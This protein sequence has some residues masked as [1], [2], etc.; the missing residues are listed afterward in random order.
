MGRDADG[1]GEGF[2]F[3]GDA[4]STDDATSDGDDWQEAESGFQFET[5]EEPEP[6]ESDDAHAVHDDHEHHPV[7]ED[8]PRGVGEA[9][10]WP[11]LTAI[12]AAAVY[13]SAALFLLGRGRNSIVAPEIGPIAFV[14]AVGI[15]LIGVYGWLYHG[16]IAHFWTRGTDRRS[17]RSL[18]WG[19]LGFIASEIATFGALFAY[20]F[21]IRAGPWPPADSLLPEIDLLNVLVVSNTAVLVLSSVT[22]HFAHHSLASG[23]RERFHRLLGITIGLGGLFLAGQIVE[24]NEFIVFEGVDWTSGVFFS[25]FFGLT[26]LHGLHV[27][28]GT[29]LLVIT[30]VRGKQGQFDEERDLSVALVSLYWHF[31]DV[32]WLFLVAALYAGAS[33]Y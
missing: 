16:F 1:D 10:W 8:W 5:A 14:G 32:V 18:R 31:V 24:Y 9:S 3:L 30:Y 29:L 13:V 23:N 2:E 4:G 25:A 21:D 11:I 22:L 26:G 28:F 33:I 27:A 17:A 7:V 20:Y 15:T 12:G 19:M 6:V